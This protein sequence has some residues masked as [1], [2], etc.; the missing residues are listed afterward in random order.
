MRRLAMQTTYG[1]PNYIGYRF[2]TLVLC[3]VDVL[4][5]SINTY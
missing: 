3:I 2:W 5:L 4:S 1:F